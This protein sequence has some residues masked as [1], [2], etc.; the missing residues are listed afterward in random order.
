MAKPTKPTKIR[1]L[2]G[3]RLRELREARGLS[4]EAFG[5]LAGV[6]GKYIQCLETAKQSTTVDTIGKLAAGL[7]VA[8]SVLF[9]FG[10]EK[11]VDARDQ[12]SGLLDKVSDEEAQRVADVVVAMLRMK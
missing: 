10:D 8:P 6:D 4:L 1:T 5:A 2:F 3:R 12:V 7:G 9:T 11:A